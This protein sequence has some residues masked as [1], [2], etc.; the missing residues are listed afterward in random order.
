MARRA[1]HG[2]NKGNAAER[3]IAKKIQEWWG[4]VEPSAK[5]MRSPGSGGWSTSEVRSEFKAHG[6]IIT[7]ATRFP[8]SIEV[9]RREQWTLKQLIKY[10]PSGPV[11]GWWIQC[12]VDAIEAQKEPLMVFRK[13]KECWR[14]FVSRPIA[15]TLNMIFDREGMKF[16]RYDFTDDSLACVQYGAIK[17][18]LIFLDTLFMI[19]A[20]FIASIPQPGLSECLSKSYPQPS[21]RSPKSTPPPTTRRR[22]NVQ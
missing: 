14:A 8:F 19:D 7:T 15:D 21:F 17:P 4:S 11:W 20:S 16:P 13:N 9:K 6:D 1:I 12:Q 10:P 3:E 5:F 2:R 18:T 22:F